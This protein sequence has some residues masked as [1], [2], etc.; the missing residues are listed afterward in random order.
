MNRHLFMT[1]R[2]LKKLVPCNQAKKL[3]E[4]QIAFRTAELDRLKVR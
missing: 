4:R 2:H 1:R 3:K